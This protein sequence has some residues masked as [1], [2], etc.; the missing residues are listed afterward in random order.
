MKNILLA[1]ALLLFLGGCDLISPNKPNDL[2][3]SV[4]FTWQLTNPESGSCSSGCFVSFTSSTPNAER[5]QWDFGDSG[6]SNS[7]D[8]LHRY[9][10]EGQWIVRLEACSKYA[11]FGDREC[12]I[13]ESVIETP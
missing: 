12:G 11:T 1:L 5:W 9:D 10:D 13:A 6:T 7:K 8:P 3:Q 4:S 2:S